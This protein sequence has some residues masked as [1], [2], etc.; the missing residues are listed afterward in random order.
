MKTK[1]D[2][3]I[4][5]YLTSYLLLA[6][7][8]IAYSQAPPDFPPPSIYTGSQFTVVPLHATNT[9][10]QFEM[11]IALNEL[12][13][14]LFIGSITTGWN[15]TDKTTTDPRGVGWYYSSDGGTSWSFDD[16]FVGGL[17]SD[18]VVGFSLDGTR[19]Y[20]YMT[21][22]TKQ[23][24]R[25]KTTSSDWIEFT[26][27]DNTYTDKNHMVIDNISSSNNVYI[28]Y[29]D[30]GSTPR[31]IMLKRSTDE[32]QSWSPQINISDGTVSDKAHAVNLSIGRDSLLYAVWACYDA[33]SFSAK[34]IAFARSTDG[35]MN[36]IGYTFVGI[37]NNPIIN[38]FQS[39]EVLT[40]KFVRINSF[41]VI[42]VDR[43]SPEGNIYVVWAVKETGTQGSFSDILFSRSSDNGVT[44]TSPKKIYHQALN[45]Q[46]DEWLPWIACDPLTG[47]IGIL[48]Y[49]S[50][51]SSD[52][53][54]AQTYF[55]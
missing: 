6:M 42:A 41:P 47:K 44:W 14:E 17:A 18:P 31:D 50:I 26:V 54:M 51:G 52:N 15:D 33:G 28:A 37:P 48:Y 2:F 29:T 46:K 55:A 19:Y 4:H 27:V 53:K 36:W 22:S 3:S 1:F 11:S 20:N 23:R 5:Y 38:G 10:T 40:D 24:I 7:S 43:N 21:G 39:G 45:N 25:R 35:G 49:S 13:G 34:R 9:A 16:H 12:T 30:N 8:I 32:G